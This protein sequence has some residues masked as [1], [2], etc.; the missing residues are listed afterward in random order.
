M[1]RP[2]KAV[3]DYFPL[4]CKWGDS[5][6]YIE[7]TYG[8]DGFI[9]WVKLLQ[10][11]GRTEYHYFDFKDMKQRKIFCAEL[12][13]NEQLIKQ[14]LDELAEF[15]CI[16][17]EL[18][19][20]EIIFSEN[21]VSSIKDAYRNRTIKP[22]F[23][24]E[25]IQLLTQQNRYCGI[26]YVRNPQSKV[27]ETIVNEIKLNETSSNEKIEPEKIEEDVFFKKF[28][29]ELSS[30]KNYPVDEEIDKE[31]LKQIQEIQPNEE[32]ILKFVKSWNM[33]FLQNPEKPRE[34]L[35]GWI[36]TNSS[37]DIKARKT[38]ENKVQQAQKKANEQ[39]V[40]A[41]EPTLEESITTKEDALNFFK[42]L[43]ERFRGVSSFHK[44]MM[45]KF[46]LT[47]AEI[48]G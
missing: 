48:V 21:F 7:D 15:D 42:G 8:N 14:I 16:D 34:R 31:L 17:K 41:A 35:L 32:K 47:K 37:E 4:V 13:L 6:K 9:C 18:W 43:P 39:A 40:I 25:V 3:V 38:A 19:K 26:S 36:K 20:Q 11:L 30:I 27:K 1:A 2:S 29:L 28:L 33:L 22:L 45:E 5:I 12:K 10:K 24:A 23:K 46:G 44:E